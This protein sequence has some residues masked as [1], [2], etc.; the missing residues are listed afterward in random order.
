LWRAC[1]GV[2]AEPSG[3]LSALLRLADCQ[4]RIARADQVIE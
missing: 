1:G 2:L 4:E 3:I